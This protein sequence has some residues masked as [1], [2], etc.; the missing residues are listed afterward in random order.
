M[1]SLGHNPCGTLAPRMYPLL[2]PHVGVALRG[3]AARSGLRQLSGGILVADLALDPRQ[4]R[5]HAAQP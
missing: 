1:Q 2:W 3:N 4:H 5:G